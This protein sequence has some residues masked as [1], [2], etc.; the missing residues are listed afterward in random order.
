MEDISEWTSC[1]G[2]YNE[3]TSFILQD[4]N[5]YGTGRY[6]GPIIVFSRS[7]F[8]KTI[9]TKSLY[10]MLRLS[11]KHVW[12]GACASKLEQVELIPIPRYS[13]YANALGPEQQGTNYFQDQVNS[14]WAQHG[15]F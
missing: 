14:D 10:R 12:S 1:H 4:T 2:Q 5:H 7:S 3:I 15:P 13:A 9:K 6:K 11:R 8:I